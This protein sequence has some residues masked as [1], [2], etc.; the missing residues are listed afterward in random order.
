MS[1]A[2]PNALH[3]DQSITVGERISAHY[4]IRHCYGGSALNVKKV[5]FPEMSGEVELY[6]I[7]VQSGAGAKFTRWIALF[8]NRLVASSLT[9]KETVQEAAI[10]LRIGVHHFTPDVERDLDLPADLR[11]P[12]NHH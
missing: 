11:V 2:T 9:R 3:E 7:L 12:A 4:A 10:M 1:T 6:R 5:K 8:D